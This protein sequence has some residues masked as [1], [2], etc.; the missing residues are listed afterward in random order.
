MIKGLLLSSVINVI[1]AHCRKFKTYRKVARKRISISC[2]TLEATTGNVLAYFLQA[3]IQQIR[4]EMLRRAL[5]RGE[6]DKWLHSSSQNSQ[7]HERRGPCVKCD[8]PEV[9]VG[10]IWPQG[11]A[12]DSGFRKGFP[13]QE[14]FKVSPEESRI[15][16]QE[17]GGV[18]MPGIGSEMW[19]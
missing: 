15:V 12:S 7:P 5:C 9:H 14:R 6:D 17:R 19:V 10:G 2:P 13:E 1:H 8:D 11:T 16:V 3:C 4:F 18:P